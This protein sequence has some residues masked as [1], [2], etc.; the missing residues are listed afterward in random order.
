MVRLCVGRYAVH[1]GTTDVIEIRPSILA[2]AEWVGEHLRDADAAEVRAAT[3]ASPVLSV[4]RS[5]A[6]STECYSIFRAE[7][8]RVMATPCAL[9]GVVPD[10]R[11]AG[12]GIVW[13]LA[14]DDIRGAGISLLRA[15]DG[16][17]DHLSRNYPKGL[18]NY[19]DKRN[20]LHIRWCKLA[21]FALGELRDIGGESFQ[22]IHR[23]SG[24]PQLV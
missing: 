11:N 15:A 14:T 19:A 3:G 17:L 13:L 18:H 1:A 10:L 4:L 9:F 12:Y 23:T 20:T 2:D 16:W 5:F 6:I 22:Y 24:A 7:R 8:G 21:G